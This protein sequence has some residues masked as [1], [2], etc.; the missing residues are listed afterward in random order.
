MLIQKFCTFLA[1]S[2]AVGVPAVIRWK[3]S[4]KNTVFPVRIS[5][6][7]VQVRARTS[8]LPIAI[9]CLTSEYD[10]IAEI[11]PDDFDGVIIDAGG[12]IGCASLRLASL[13]PRARIICIEPASDNL[14]LL[15]SNTRN[16]PKIEVRKAAL[17]A[18]ATGRITL[19][20]RGRGG[21]GYTVVRDS[22][23]VPNSTQLENVEAISITELLEEFGDNIGFVK[24]DIEGA[25]R[26]ILASHSFRERDIPAVFVELHERIKQGCNEVFRAFSAGRWTLRIGPEK[27]LSLSG[28]KMPGN[29]TNSNPPVP[30]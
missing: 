15:L 13:F 21:S 18:E 26:D 17:V 14:R 22:E 30:K 24:L 11:L 25:E 1:L 5:E 10:S 9:D 20:D 27:F 6:F 28:T 3:L 2:S 4:P 29:G 16:V 8:D 7:D 12:H 19:S 23:D